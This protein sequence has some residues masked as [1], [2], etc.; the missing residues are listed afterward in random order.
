VIWS[1]LG[2]KAVIQTKSTCVNVFSYNKETRVWTQRYCF[3]GA[4]V[5]LGGKVEHSYPN[6]NRDCAFS[7]SGSSV[8][9]SQASSLY[10]FDLKKGVRTSIGPGNDIYGY[11][12]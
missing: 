5:V 4:R 8:L 12:I 1:R 9:L 10:L 11:D 3:V 2:T 7:P 6:S